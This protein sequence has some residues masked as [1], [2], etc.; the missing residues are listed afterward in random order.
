MIAGFQGLV[1][2]AAF[3]IVGIRTPVVWGI[4]MAFFSLL[5]VVGSWPIWVPAAIWMFATGH[6]VSGIVLLAICGGLVGTVENFI[7]PTLISGR[8]RLN[9]LLIFISVLGGI[10]AFGML[11]IVLGPIV[12]ATAISILDVYTQSD[13][14]A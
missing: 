6:I 7:R 13:L 12:V 11:G 4:V 8:T 5:P 9:E 3:A 2:G 10:A 14:P 1:D